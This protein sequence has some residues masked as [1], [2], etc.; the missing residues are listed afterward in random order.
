MPSVKS[1]H[2]VAVVV[3]DVHSSLAFWQDAL[4]MSV[5]G[6]RDVASEQ[7]R[8]AFLPL[9]GSQLE[10]VQPTT[11][12]SGLARFLEKRGPGMHH[13]CLEVDD[14]PGMLAQLASSGI[15]LINDQPRTGSEG[16]LYAFVHPES[17]GGVLVEL[18]QS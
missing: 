5:S 17:T 11:S 16:R 15:R 13:V 10:L 8:I 1:I 14:L 18:Y 7:A 6:S 9:G 12:E 2:H 4:G 3:P